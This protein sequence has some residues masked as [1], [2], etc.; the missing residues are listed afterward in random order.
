MKFVLFV[1]GY[2]ERALPEFLKRWLD[3]LTLPVGIRT[4]RFNGW[5]HYEDEIAKKVALNL[6]GKAGEDVI[7]GI[8]LLDLYGPTFYPPHKKTVVERAA[9][10]RTHLETRAGHPRFRQ[11]F[12]IHEVEA[13][14]LADPNI[15]PEVVRTA[16]PGRAAQPETVN[17]SEPPSRLLGRLYRSKLNQPYKKVI[18]GANLFHDLVPDVAHAKCPGLRMLLED[19]LAQARAIP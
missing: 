1:E 10:A 15:L 3:R 12:A 6:S 7:A 11:Y 14:L 13:W 5:R 8:G 17:F 16:L 18:D 19:M 4:V 2:T 9:W